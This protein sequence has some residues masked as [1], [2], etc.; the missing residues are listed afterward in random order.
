[1]HRAKRLGQTKDLGSHISFFQD[2]V[3]SLSDST[4]FE[5][6][7]GIFPHVQLVKGSPS[8]EIEEHGIH[9]LPSFRSSDKCSESNHASSQRWHATGNLDIK[10]R[11]HIRIDTSSTRDPGN[12]LTRLTS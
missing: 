6:V 2:G 8:I 7:V 10:M 12:A 3:W 1:M 9:L 4:E 11:S 5:Y